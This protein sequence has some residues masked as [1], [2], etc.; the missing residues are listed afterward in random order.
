VVFGD[1]LSPPG[2][3]HHLGQHEV[4]REVEPAGLEAEVKLSLTCAA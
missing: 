2:L 1:E 4:Q 3:A